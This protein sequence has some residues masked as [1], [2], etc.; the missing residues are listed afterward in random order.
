MPPKKRK[1]FNPDSKQ[2]IAREYIQGHFDD[3]PCSEGLL[4]GHV[5]YMYLQS[6]SLARTVVTVT[7]LTPLWRSTKYMVDK[8]VSGMLRGKYKQLTDQKQFDSFKFI[9]NLPFGVS[10]S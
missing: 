4:N 1:R 8:L 7:Q 9:C 2:G 3:E 10:H 6:G 5:I